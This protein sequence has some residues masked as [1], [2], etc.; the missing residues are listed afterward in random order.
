M[1]VVALRTGLRQGEL[2][3]LRWQDVDLVNRR[4]VVRR[5]VWQGHIGSTQRG[6]QS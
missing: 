4:M 3:A 2:L 5:A 1:V 6:P